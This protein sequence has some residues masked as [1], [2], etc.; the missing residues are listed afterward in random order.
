MVRAQTKTHINLTN[1]VSCLNFPPTSALSTAMCYN[2]LSELLGVFLLASLGR[3]WLLDV[4]AG[5]SSP[6]SFFVEL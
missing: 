4:G 5:G 6:C 1:S 3:R 2:L